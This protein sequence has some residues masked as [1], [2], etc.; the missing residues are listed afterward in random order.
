MQLSFVSP[1][2][3]MLSVY[4]IGCF[5]DEGDIYFK[6]MAY[7]VDKVLDAYRQELVDVEQKV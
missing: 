4:Y 7:G 2:W 5:P 1:A 3:N 6:A